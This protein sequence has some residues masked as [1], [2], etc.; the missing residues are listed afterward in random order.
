MPKRI[1]SPYKMSGID[2]GAGT[3]GAYSTTDGKLMS[4]TGHGGALGSDALGNSRDSYMGRLNEEGTGQKIFS[5]YSSD[6]YDHERGTALVH[7]KT[8]NTNT[9]KALYGT[10]TKPKVK[11]SSSSSRGTGKN[12][13]KPTKGQRMA[14]FQ[15]EGTTTRRQKRLIKKGRADKAWRISD[16]RRRRTLRRGGEV[17]STR[18]TSSKRAT[19]TKKKQG[20]AAQL[21]RTKYRGSG[22]INYSSVNKGKGGGGFFRRRNRS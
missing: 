8:M 17:A 3:G 14:D 4:G 7:G 10:D 16:R 5:P 15:G 21:K 12:L 6:A 19:S 11:S 20:N 2:F 18:G 13:S 1:R 22:N 9:Q